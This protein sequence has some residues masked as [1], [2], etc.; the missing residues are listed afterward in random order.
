A[1]KLRETLFREAIG[2][3]SRQVLGEA[4]RMLLPRWQAGIFNGQ[5]NEALDGHPL[6]RCI[7]Y[8]RVS[9]LKAFLT[10]QGVPM[11]PCLFENHPEPAYHCGRLLAVLADLQKTALGDVGAGVV[12][13]YYARASTAP[14]DAL[15]P[16]IN[17]SNRHLD[18][19]ADKGLA[20][21]LQGNIAE[22]WG[23]I[24]REYPPKSLDSIGQSLF[25]M[26]FYQQIAHMRHERRA[27]AA[28]KRQE[29]QQVNVGAAEVAD[30]DTNSIIDS[31]DEG[32]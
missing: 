30:T 11:E 32:D 14:A 5:F 31:N 2:Y 19:I 7:L 1:G 4:A 25:A 27:N 9:L 28:K 12:Q 22:I 8:A 21:Y 29:G 20:D 6:H 23:K 24:S 18:K 15:G 13:R 17:L 26:G 3:G 16:L 10:R